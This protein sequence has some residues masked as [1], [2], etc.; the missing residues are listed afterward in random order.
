[1]SSDEL[2]LPDYRLTRLSLGGWGLD[3]LTVKSSLS[4]YFQ[5]GDR[6][7]VSWS[8]VRIG[9]EDLEVIQKR[10]RLARTLLESKL[11][12]AVLAL[13]HFLEFYCGAPKRT[14]A[15]DSSNLAERR[16]YRKALQPAWESL[17]PVAESLKFGELDL[18]KRSMLELAVYTAT[19]RGALMADKLKVIEDCWSVYANAT[20]PEG[21]PVKAHAIIR[22][23]FYAGVAF[24][25]DLMIA[26]CEDEPSGVAMLDSVEAELNEHSQ[27]LAAHLGVDIN[28]I[29]Q[30]IAD[31]MRRR[32]G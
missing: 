22:E 30:A 26:N 23:A 17:H 8:V 12:N 21:A 6:T 31:E 15:P 13:G 4:G 9:L 25:F 24:M 18:L 16:R 10:E 3:G 29:R 32:R 2:V 14:V 19:Q 20:I 1:M 28:S 27:D 5:S 11:R 7:V